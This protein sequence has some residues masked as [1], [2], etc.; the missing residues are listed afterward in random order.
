MILVP[1][2]LQVTV[3]VPVP[4]VKDSKSYDSYGSGSTTLLIPFYAFRCFLWFNGKIVKPVREYRDELVLIPLLCHQVLFML[5][6]I[7]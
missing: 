7:G 6:S 1:N 3:P 4:L 5:L 2:F